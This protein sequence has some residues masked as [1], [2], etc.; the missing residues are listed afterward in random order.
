MAARAITTPKKPKEAP[1]AITQESIIEE[2]IRVRAHE[3]YVQRG[4][5]HGSD[6]DDWLQ[7]EQEIRNVD[8]QKSI[9]R[10]EGEGLAP[11]K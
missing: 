8:E 1:E 6:L 11:R 3:I 5:K 10:A 2:R 9:A 4:G 7:A